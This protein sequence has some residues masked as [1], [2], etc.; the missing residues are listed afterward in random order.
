MPV[1]IDVFLWPKKQKDETLI[2]LKNTILKGWP[3]KR[4]E[5]PQNLKSYW[6]YRDELSVLD[7]LILRGT[8]III[9]SE[10][11]DEVLEKT[12]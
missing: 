1:R 4:D 5:C 9:P 10:C 2:T 12:S 7:S 3:E 6:N 8:R 11:R